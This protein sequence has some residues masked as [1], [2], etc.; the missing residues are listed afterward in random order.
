MKRPSN[1][2]ITVF[3]LAVSVILL[4][5]FEGCRGQENPR[6]IGARYGRFDLDKITFSEHLDTLFARAEKYY[7]MPKGT[8]VFDSKLGR[9]VLTDTLYSVYRIPAK[10]VTEGTYSF[11]TLRIQPREVVDFYA[12]RLNKFRKAEVSVYMSTKEY[13]QLRADCKD[14]KNI[15]TTSVNKLNNGKYQIFQDTD[16][17]NQVQTT[18]YC[19]ENTDTAEGERFF[20]RIS[21]L[22]LKIRNDGFYK[23]LNDN[24]K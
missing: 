3:K 22:D 2:Q 17:K 24:L 9:Y 8:E 5:T 11:K 4:C 18:L 16:Q 10:N 14:F 1:G 12:D 21:R 20:V 13:A 19:L 6:H 23:Q 15:T 7:K